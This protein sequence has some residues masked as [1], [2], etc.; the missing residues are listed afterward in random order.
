MA[1]L[2]AQV[3]C[4]A[5]N[6]LTIINVMAIAILQ[7]VQPLQQHTHPLWRYNGTDDATR[8]MRK[9]FKDQAAITTAL[10]GIFKGEK[11]DFDQ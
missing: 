3:T 9:G 6:R 1:R 5:D 7:G 11:E 4:L 10:S 2:A 8:S